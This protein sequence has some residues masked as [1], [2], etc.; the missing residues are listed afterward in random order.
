MDE[1]IDKV[2]REGW[3]RRGLWIGLGGLGIIFLCLLVCGSIVFLAAVGR[4]GPIQGIAPYV[5]PPAGEE[6]VAPLTSHGPFGV[7]RTAGWGLFGILSMGL[8]LLFKILL[9]GLFLLLL[10]RLVRHLVWGRCYYSPYAWARPSRSPA[11]S[12]RGEGGNARTDWGP[13]AWH[14]PRGHWGPPPWWG[15]HP[16]QDGKAEAGED[17]PGEA[18]V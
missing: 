1:R 4:S 10:F 11:G 7:S 6:G 18:S 3:A 2:H 15:P 5:Q 16:E 12:A 8:G 13:R 9:L 17:Q 14:H